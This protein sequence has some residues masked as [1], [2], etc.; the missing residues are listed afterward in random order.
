MKNKLLEH[1][2]GVL[3]VTLALVAA[4]WAVTV[5]VSAS[6]QWP[7]GR[8]GGPASG[9]RHSSTAGRSERVVQTYAKAVVV[10]GPE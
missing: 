9:S 5:L 3:F 10:A 7:D 1:F 6:A 2:A 4:L 8:A